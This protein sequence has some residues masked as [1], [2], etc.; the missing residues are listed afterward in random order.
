[1]FDPDAPLPRIVGGGG[2]GG[3]AGLHAIALLTMS[4]NAVRQREAP[5]GLA[6]VSR[7]A[8]AEGRTR[9]RKVTVQKSE[10]TNGASGA[11]VFTTHRK[12][13]PMSKNPTNGTIDPRRWRRSIRNVASAVR[14]VMTTGV[15]QDRD[16]LIASTPGCC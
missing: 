1:V 9:A 3:G 4:V 11:I 6:T 16:R 13:A 2:C 10:Y 8:R 12:S 15:S 7:D 14:E 5:I